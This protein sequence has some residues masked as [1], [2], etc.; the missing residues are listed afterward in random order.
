MPKLKTP[1]DKYE[2][3]KVLVRGYM[4]LYGATQQTVADWFGCARQTVNYKL[5][6]PELLTLS[7]VNTLQRRLHI[8]ADSMRAAIPF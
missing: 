4:G 2:N 1:P 3:F 8:P 7:E 6:S 5:R